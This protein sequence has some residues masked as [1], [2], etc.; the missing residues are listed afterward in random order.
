VRAL[1]YSRSATLTLP[2]G[3]TADIVALARYAEHLLGKLWEPGTV[4]VKA[5]VV[6]DGLEP[7]SSGQQLGLFE[8]PVARAVAPPPVATDRPRLMGSWPCPI[9]RSI[10]A[11]P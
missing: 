10:C 4:Y 3:P 2:A 11:A 8:P 7:P 1:P 6:L 5:G 9:A